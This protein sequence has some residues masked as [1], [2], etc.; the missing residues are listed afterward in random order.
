MLYQSPLGTDAAFLQAL[1]QRRRQLP[2]DQIRQHIQRQLQQAGLPAVF[3]D[4]SFATLEEHQAPEAF[5]ISRLY[6]DQG[7]YEGKKGLLLM[8][9][10]GRGKSSLAVAV[11]RQVVERTQGLYSVRF[12][13]ISQGLDQ[14]RERFRQ[15][16]GAGEDLRE[17]LYH[18]L[19]VLDDWGKQRMTEWV[20][21][22]FYRLIDGLW[23]EQKA[24]VLTTN[25]SLDTLGE[26]FEEALLSR[27]LGMCH[28][29]VVQGKDRRLCS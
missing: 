6:A 19:V 21:E 12:W 5:R 28:V 11:L 10:P 25:L 27:V 8:G 26:R 4:C 3:R 14:L 2:A 16:E 13:N 15:E 20:A 22:Q 1:Q 9:R 18:R 23:A 7:E 29:V 24:V 17:L